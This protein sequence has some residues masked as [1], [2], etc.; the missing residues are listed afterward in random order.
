[1]LR[2]HGKRSKK[3]IRSVQAMSAEIMS[4]KRI[5]LQMRIKINVLSMA[6]IHG[7]GNSRQAISNN[8]SN[9]TGYYMAT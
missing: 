9:T 6:Q 3:G 7:H 1:M 2:E 5:N 8:D 4:T